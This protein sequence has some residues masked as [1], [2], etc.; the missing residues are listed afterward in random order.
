MEEISSSTIS[1]STMIY[2]I[3]FSSSRFSVIISFL[4]SWKRLWRGRRWGRWRRCGKWR[5]CGEM[6]EVVKI[7]VVEEMSYKFNLKS[8]T[9]KGTIGNCVVYSEEHFSAA[10][11]VLK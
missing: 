11:W 4:G 10:K 3:M 6:E 1:F 5:R 7:K 2:S 8:S 9:V